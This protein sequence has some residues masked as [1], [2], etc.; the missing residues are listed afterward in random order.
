MKVGEEAEEREVVVPFRLE[1][2]G[3]LLAI[4]GFDD[5]NLTIMARLDCADRAWSVSPIAGRALYG[6]GAA[7]VGS[8]VYVTG[9]NDRMDE[10][11]ATVEALDVVNG[12]W[13][14]KQSMGQ[15]RSR[16]GVAV[17]GALVYTVGGRDA[18]GKFLSSAEVYDPQLNQ[19]TN[20][21]PMSTARSGAAVCALGGRVYACG[22]YNGPGGD[23]YNGPGGGGGQSTVEVYDPAQA[24]W[25]PCAPMPLALW[26]TSAAAIGGR[27]YV[28]GGYPS[29]ETV[30]SY[31]PAAD[32]WRQEPSM[33]Y[34][35]YDHAMAS[36]ANL[37]YVSGGFGHL[38]TSSFTQSAFYAKRLASTEVFDPATGAWTLLPAMPEAYRGHA[39][40][41]T[42]RG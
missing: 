35:R 41:H 32:E 18:S 31:S 12:K 22:G 13:T 24:A 10:T 37:I 19:W 27:V 33:H 7:V 20:L 1:P 28:C 30:I 39:L 29:L 26:G 2:P 17:I 36:V 40:V 4:G 6:L 21:P 23:G 14:V 25:S 5:E 34:A 3:A 15:P 42:E 8:N 9:G 16:H 11:I 38:A